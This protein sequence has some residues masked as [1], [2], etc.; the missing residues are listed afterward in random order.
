MTGG[1]DVEL[2]GPAEQ[3]FLTNAN[4]AGERDREGLRAEIEGH[5]ADVAR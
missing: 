1:F 5:R 4:V 2:I 3:P